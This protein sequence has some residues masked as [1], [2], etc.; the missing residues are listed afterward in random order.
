MIR[1]RRRVCSVLIAWLLT[2]GLVLHATA[3]LWHVPP[4]PAP[5]QAL[6][7]SSLELFDQRSASSTVWPAHFLCIPARHDQAPMPFSGSD[8]DDPV[9]PSPDNIAAK[10]P[11]CTLLQIASLALPP[12]NPD[13]APWTGRLVHEPRP[14]LEQ[15]GE[16]F[17]KAYFSRAPP[18]PHFA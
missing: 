14:V 13:F 15:S 4:S 18:S 16:T 9:A 5:A 8:E 11:I 12:R 6:D 3:P 17:F 7:L 10:C 1:L 2:A